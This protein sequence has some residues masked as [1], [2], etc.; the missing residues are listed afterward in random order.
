MTT[1]GFGLIQILGGLLLAPVLSGAIIA[2]AARLQGL[3]GPSPLQPWRDLI[4]Y[5][6]RA[7]ISPQPRTIV[8]EFAPLLL[9]ASI[10][11]ALLMVPI[12]GVSPSW[13]FGNDAI[14][15]VG[16][17]AV[18]RFA[19]A[20]SSWDV[21]SGFALMGAARDLTIAVFA[22]SLLLLTIV[23]LASTAG[24]TDLIEIGAATAGSAPWSDPAHWCAIAAFALVVIAETGRRPIDNPET[25]LELTM[26]HEGPLLEYGGRDL[27]LLHWSAAARQ[28][29]LFVLAAELLLPHA[30]GWAARLGMLAVSLLAL[31]LVVAYSESVQAKMR[32]LRAPALLGVGGLLALV[33][34]AI[35]LAGGLG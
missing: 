5:W 25:H 17:L 9:T 2:L 30:G 29:I 28:W 26:I 24:S 8:Y 32:I 34:L 21:G 22:E 19:L 12:A 7:R 27:T 6:R 14:V 3:R 20:A 1:L 35:S 11:L 15:L 16:L 23:L 31:V 10:A 13:P 18:G 4:K 33:G